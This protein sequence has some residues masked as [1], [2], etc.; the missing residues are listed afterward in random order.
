M[1]KL[2]SKELRQFPLPPAGYKSAFFPADLPAQSVIRFWI[3]TS[4]R[5]E[6]DPSVYF[7]LHFY[8]KRG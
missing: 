4:L 2:S 5:D 1:V 7:N 8:Y 3:I 6:N